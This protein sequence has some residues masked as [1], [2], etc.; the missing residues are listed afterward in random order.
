MQRL[1]KMASQ[2]KRDALRS[3]IRR[4]CQNGISNQRLDLILEG[5]NVNRPYSI[6][7]TRDYGRFLNIATVE[8]VATPERKTLSYVTSLYGDFKCGF[9]FKSERESCSI[10]GEINSERD[11][12][13]VKQTIVQH[14]GEPATVTYTLVLYESRKGRFV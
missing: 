11:A 2:E 5:L 7:T 9:F 1:S 10:P 6:K 4:K 14:R 8:T 13:A 12:A 3:A